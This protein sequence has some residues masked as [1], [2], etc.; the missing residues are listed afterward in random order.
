MARR[1]IQSVRNVAKVIGVL[2]GLLVF[3]GLGLETTRAT[4]DYAPVV[5]DVRHGVYI[6]A[7]CY[8][9]DPDK[10]QDVIV[11]WETLGEARKQG[12]K[13]YCWNADNPERIGTDRTLLT[14]VLSRVGLIK[15]PYWWDH[16]WFDSQPTAHDGLSAEGA[17]TSPS[18][19]GR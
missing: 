9:D 2:V 17:A 14:S 4:P 12:F 3:L 11:G 18:S 7:V 15:S 16:R 1:I 19:A 8:G 13:G 5:V 6:P 10:A